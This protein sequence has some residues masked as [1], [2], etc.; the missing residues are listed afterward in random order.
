[1]LHWEFLHATGIRYTADVSSE[2]DVRAAQQRKR[3]SSACHNGCRVSC[4]DRVANM[5]LSEA[6]DS[7][8]THLRARGKALGTIK[9]R[10]GT[11]R[12]LIDAVG[13]LQTARVTAQHVD[14]LFT[15]N[16]DNWN[17]GTRNNHLTNLRCFFEWAKFRG[18]MRR[19]L[20]PMFGWERLSYPR[21][22]R[23]QI[24]VAEWS[25]LFAAAVH[26][27]ETITVA[28]GLFLF[29]RGS[30]QQQLQL[31]HVHL[32]RHEIEVHRVKTR[33]WDVMPISSELDVFMRQ[34]LTWLSEQ[35][36]VDSEHYLIPT[37]LP[38]R[39]QK[40][41]QGF[42]RGETGINPTRAFGRPYAVV[43][44]VLERAGYPTFNEG[45]H[46]LRRS[47]ARAY[48]DELVASGY[49]GALKRVQ[50][51]LDHQSA[52]ETERYLELTLD[53]HRRN[54]DLRGKPMFPALHDARVVAMRGVC[55]GSR[56]AAAL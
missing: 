49:D 41:Q 30:E 25:R 55:G 38:A 1:M 35:G 53:K 12:S 20:D 32:D 50:A 52:A 16:A 54:L 10:Q 29:L 4:C 21:P 15:S 17:A 14:T 24:P 44:S 5:R 13:D 40:G 3:C 22:P 48:F 42:R 6:S 2:D 31:K 34:H 27:I 18:L 26:P 28:T 47:G 56:D 46:T 51:M 33:R 39:S 8:A 36:A 23:L 19:D 37:R 9:L 7:Y 45:E 43:Q 11:L